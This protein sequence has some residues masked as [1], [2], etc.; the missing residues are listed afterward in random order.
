MS[1]L[2]LSTINQ[3]KSFQIQ[4]LQDQPLQDQPNQQN[5]VNYSCPS[6]NKSIDSSSVF[7]W[8]LE[9]TDE[10]EFNFDELNSILNLFS[11]YNRG[12]GSIKQKMWLYINVYLMNDRSNVSPRIWKFKVG[13]IQEMNE[14]MRV[15]VRVFESFPY[16]YILYGRT[17]Q[18]IYDIVTE[19]FNEDDINVFNEIYKMRQETPH[20]QFKKVFPLNIKFLHAEIILTRK[21]ATKC[22]MVRLIRREI[23]YLNE[24]RN[25]TM[26]RLIG[27]QRELIL[28]DIQYFKENIGQLVNDYG[29]KLPNNLAHEVFRHERIFKILTIQRQLEDKVSLNVKH[30]IENRDLN[31][32]LMEFIN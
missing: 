28:K 11:G 14:S 13:D 20:E 10:V 5:Y 31:R 23:D 21:F 8:T 15:N 18:E 22:R 25:H 19:H 7:S 16:N 3:S 26:E 17:Q 32:Y 29:I 12:H 9:P 1:V 6:I 4:P 27:E 2:K 30:V 24:H